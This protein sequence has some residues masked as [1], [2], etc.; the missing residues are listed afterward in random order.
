MPGHDRDLGIGL[1]ELSE[2]YP[3]LAHLAATAALPRCK[4]AVVADPGDAAAG[5][6]LGVARWQL[7]KRD[8]AMQALVAVLGQEP[9]REATLTYA[10]VLAEESGQPVIARDFWRRAIAVNPWV[11]RY[12]HRYSALLAQEQRWAEA[13]PAAEAARRLNPASEETRSLLCS[14]YLHVGKRQ[15]AEAELRILTTLHPTDE[16]VLRRWFA[17]LSP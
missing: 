7:G 2:S 15:Q 14:I 16:S 17:E 13:L 4:A 12:Q 5:E 9:N 8:E 6:A 11:S 10:A 3:T 1:A